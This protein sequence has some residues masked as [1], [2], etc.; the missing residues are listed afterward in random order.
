MTKIKLCGIRRFEDVDYV[1]ELMPEYIGFI[2]AKKS[3]RYVV[4]DE[5]LRLKKRLYKDIKAVGVFVD[6]SMYN[7]I[8]L[9]D[10]NI[11]DMVQLHGDEDETYIE[12]LRQ[13]TGC[14]IIKAF[15]ISSAKDM[16]NAL[17]STADYILLDSGGGSG[18]TFDWSVIKGAAIDR[19]YFLAGGLEPA[20][21]GMA[22]Q[23]LKPYAVDASSSL[24]TEGYKDREKM[25][26]FVDAV[27]EI[28]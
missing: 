10:Q 23:K 9:L 6:E 18:E 15:K 25:K 7:I 19:P 8:E 14:E 2:F 22:I 1:N 21:I 24:E 28:G 27:R 4:P 17:K 16:K 5:A 20:N 13:A 11:I 12:R 3:K 26:A